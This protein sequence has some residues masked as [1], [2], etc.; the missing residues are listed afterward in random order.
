[1]TE[2]CQTA[3]QGFSGFFPAISLPGLRLL[4]RVVV[5]SMILLGFSA[6]GEPRKIFT[7]SFPARQGK[8]E[9]ALPCSLAPLRRRR[10]HCHPRGRNAIIRPGK[11]A[12]LQ[13]ARSAPQHIEPQRQRRTEP[14]RKSGMVGDA[15][16][17]ERVHQDVQPF[18]VEHQPG[19]QPRE[20]LACEGH[21]I[22]RDRMRSDRLVVPTSEPSLEAVADRRAQAFRDRPGAAES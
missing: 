16:A 18:A 13:G 15:V 14:S 19:H 7:L 2:R 8:M 12:P 22:H 9:T 10:G 5:K 17:A 21:L 20:L 3:I 1:M 4:P 11:P 6:R